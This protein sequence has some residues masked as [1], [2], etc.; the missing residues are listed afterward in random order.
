MADRVLRYTSTSSRPGR[1]VIDSVLWTG[2]GT[3]GDDLVLQDTAGD[4]IIALTAS[5]TNYS[6]TW[7]PSSPFY[8]DGVNV[9]TIDSGEVFIYY[10]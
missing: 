10:R 7:V 5:G 8:S 3:A 9:A 2:A 4:P 1:I 6:E